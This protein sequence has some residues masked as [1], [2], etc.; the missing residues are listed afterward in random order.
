MDAAKAAGKDLQ[1]AYNSADP[2]P[3]AALDNVFEPGV[4]DMCLAESRPTSA[5][6]E[7]P[8]PREQ[9]NLKASFKP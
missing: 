9:E 6:T 7:N 4:L 1:A 8:S 5:R 2:F 3:H